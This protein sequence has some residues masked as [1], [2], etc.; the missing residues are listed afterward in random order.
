[1]QTGPALSRLAGQLIRRDAVAA[2]LET[3]VPALSPDRFRNA[4]G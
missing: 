1:M 3:I 2:D 4:A